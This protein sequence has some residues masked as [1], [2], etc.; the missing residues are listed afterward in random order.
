MLVTTVMGLWCQVTILGPEAERLAS[1]PLSGAG[2]PDL[3]VVEGLARLQLA[4]HRH[5]NRVML[6][7]VCAELLELL[8]LVGLRVEVGGQAEG[9]ED[10]LGIEKNV[11]TT[12]P[13]S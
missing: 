10:S 6:T 13:P 1:W 11:E 3:A 12:D 2:C 4:A 8:D 5:G 9:G 7:E